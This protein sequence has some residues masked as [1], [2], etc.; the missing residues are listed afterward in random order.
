MNPSSWTAFNQGADHALPQAAKDERHALELKQFQ[1]IIDTNYSVQLTNNF[2]IQNSKS[3][4]K[5]TIS[6]IIVAAASAFFAF[7]A[8]YATLNDA[9]SKELKYLRQQLQEQS[10]AQEQMKL[11][12]KGIDS[13]MK[14]FL[15][16][17]DTINH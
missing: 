3:Q 5:L 2:L 8:M 14:D 6:S 12:Q 7:G 1:S 11:F 10:N 17:S 9:T 15:L 4:N 16:I 13:S